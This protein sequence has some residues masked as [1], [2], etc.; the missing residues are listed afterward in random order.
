MDD[1]TV[2]AG[3]ENQFGLV[4]GRNNLVGPERRPLSAMTPT[5]VLDPADRLRMILGSPGGPRIITAVAQVI[6]NVVDFGMSARAAVDAPRVHHQLLP[7]EIGLERQGVDGITLGTLAQMGHEVSP[8]SGY[9]GEVELIL[10]TGDGTY[11]GVSD[12]RRQG[13]RALAY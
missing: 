3:Y 8:G 13:G 7:D 4:Q 1:F 5:I 9:F 10:R 6:I 12:P 2:R 11:V